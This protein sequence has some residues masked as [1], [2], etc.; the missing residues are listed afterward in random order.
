MSRDGDW[1]AAEGVDH[2][3][4]VLG[5]SGSVAAGGIADAPKGT[6]EEDLGGARTRVETDLED[7]LAVFRHNG[8]LSD[9]FPG[10]PEHKNLKD[11][12]SLGSQCEADVLV[13][14]VGELGERAVVVVGRA[15]GAG[16]D[17][18][19]SCPCDCGVDVGR[20]EVMIARRGWGWKEGKRFA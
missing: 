19:G 16:R 10:G 5:E 12:G 13:G 8:T 14:V 9:V 17:V 20:H 3:A 18:V 7:A 6:F 11:A 15:G 2:K 1:A 4:D